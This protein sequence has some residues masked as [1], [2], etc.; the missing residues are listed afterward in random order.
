MTKPKKTSIHSDRQTLSEL[1]RLIEQDVKRGADSW[2]SS[3][4]SLPVL[5]P[6]QIPELMDAIQ[7]TREIASAAIYQAS[8]GN[9]HFG[10]SKADL[11]LGALWGELKTLRDGGESEALQPIG[12]ESTRRFESAQAWTLLKECGVISFQWMKKY[13]HP[14]GN[15]TERIIKASDDLLSRDKIRRARERMREAGTLD[16]VEA[17]FDAAAIA[18]VDLKC[19]NLPYDTLRQRR[20][21]WILFQVSLRAERVKKSH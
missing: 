6:Q 19:I 4:K 12:I 18:D 20:I 13:N 10:Y 2:L 1:S 3:K 11:L 8:N 21:D 14:A 15:K 7:F 9:Q 16:S 5:S 17:Q